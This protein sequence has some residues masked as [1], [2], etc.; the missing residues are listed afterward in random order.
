MKLLLRVW[1]A[2]MQSTGWV[3]D[4]RVGIIRDTFDGPWRHLVHPTDRRSRHGPR[5]QVRSGLG[6]LPVFDLSMD[7]G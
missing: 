7:A 6:C 2:D 5:W 3:E 1:P 4:P